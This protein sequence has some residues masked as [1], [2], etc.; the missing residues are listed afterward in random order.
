M[1]MGE[2]GQLKETQVQQQLS[3]C[4][5]NLDNL[6]GSIKELEARL[7]GVI[8]SSKADKEQEAP[9]QQFVTLAN[10]VRSI[11]DRVMLATNKIN[12]LRNRIEL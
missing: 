8:V 6:E 10:N 5:G 4:C 12:D 3:R 11:A 9:V 7:Q 1:A 2:G